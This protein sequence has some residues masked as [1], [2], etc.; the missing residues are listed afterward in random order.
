LVN[1]T[2]PEKGVETNCYADEKPYPKDGHKEEVFSHSEWLEA[3]R[4]VGK[5]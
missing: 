2:L 5:W 4:R 1:G 3:V